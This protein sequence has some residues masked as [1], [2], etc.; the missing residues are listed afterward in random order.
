MIIIEEAPPDESKAALDPNEGKSSR[1]Q[2]FEK[3]IEKTARAKKSALRIALKLLGQ[4][5]RELLR[6]CHEDDPDADLLDIA[7][8]LLNHPSLLSSQSTYSVMEPS[9]RLPTSPSKNNLRTPPKH[10][11]SMT[12]SKPLHS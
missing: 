10:G 6:R 8:Y 3:L 4:E 11:G 9:I 5:F 1:E 2:S 12:Y 7:T